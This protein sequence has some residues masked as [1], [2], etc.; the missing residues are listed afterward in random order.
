[1]HQNEQFSFAMQGN[2]SIEF[3]EMCKKGSNI[4]ITITDLKQIFDTLQAKREAIGMHTLEYKELRASLFGLATDA[5]ITKVIPVKSDT[6]K[7]LEMI[8]DWSDENAS[9][10]ITTVSE[11]TTEDTASKKHKKHKKKKKKKKKPDI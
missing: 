1:M 10:E 5:S 8:R 9:S 4:S 2:E 7:E 3:E 11:E 6:P